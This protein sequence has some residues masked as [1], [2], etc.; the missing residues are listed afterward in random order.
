MSVGLGEE[1]PSGEPRRA[2]GDVVSIVRKDFDNPVQQLR[3]FQFLSQ[4][5]EGFDV[6]PLSPALTAKP[7]AF[8]LGMGKALP[9]GQ[10][11]PIGE[12]LRTIHRLWLCVETARDAPCHYSGRRF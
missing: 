5:P 8:L 10:K 9:L 12:V 3:S 6:D 1:F 2:I 11:A 4:L 7:R